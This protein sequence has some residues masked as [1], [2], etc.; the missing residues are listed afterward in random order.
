MLKHPDLAPARSAVDSFD[1]SAL[2][3]S[4]VL[5]DL[6]ALVAVDHLTVAKVLAHL[7]EVDRRRLY[8]S[9]GYSSMFAYCVEELGFSEDVTCVRLDVARRA[10]EFPGLLSAIAQGRLHLSG[11]RMLL[12][13]MTRENNEDLIANATH[14]TRRQ[15]EILLADRFPP[16]ELMRLDEGISAL[17]V[18]G[19]MNPPVPGRVKS[20]IPE[21]AAQSRSVPIGEQRFSVQFT[22]SKR[23]HD[24]LREIQALLSHAIPS[25]DISDIFDRSLDALLLL[26]SR[27]KLSSTDRPRP[28]DQQLR[29]S[30]HIPAS[31]KRAVW[32]R[33]GGRCTFVGT[34][35]HRCGET[36]FL[37]FDHA[38]PVAKGGKATV[39]NLRLRCRTHNRLE[40]VR[41]FGEEFMKRMEGRPKDPGPPRS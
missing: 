18:P 16:V 7:A 8:A 35:G 12:P 41:Q 32:E 5:H 1:L 39:D 22:V 38:R 3:D 28:A 27:R 14:R 19:R 21:P 20:A 25:R 36:E 26:V 13:H 2:P 37:E 40:A 6:N 15:I 34:D 9:V 30:R 33:D 24:K 10:R 23:T 11:A 4:T 31:V 17:S 29:G